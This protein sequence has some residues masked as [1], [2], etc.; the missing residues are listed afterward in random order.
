MAK[1][2]SLTSLKQRSKFLEQM[3]G[4]KKEKNDALN[5]LVYEK[6]R[7]IVELNRKIEYLLQE[8]RYEV[9]EIL[10]SI[11]NNEIDDEMLNQLME[12]YNTV[13]E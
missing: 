8:Q 6:N 13:D 4:H 11:K 10:S 9:M 7:Q 3:V 1:E 5:R 2:E 12:K